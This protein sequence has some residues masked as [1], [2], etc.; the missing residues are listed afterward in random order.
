MGSIT[1]QLRIYWI[2]FFVSVIV[3]TGLSITGFHS[4]QSGGIPEN[5]IDKVNELCQWIFRLTMLFSIVLL[6]LGATIYYRTERGFILWL[7]LLI[8]VV[9]IMMT[10][11]FIEG[12]LF[13]FK[14]EHNLWEGGFSV[15]P[16]IGIFLSLFSG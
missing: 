14:K 9:F 1:N 15:S 3:L 4:L 5:V 12:Q 13:Q 8:L 10:F 7:P 11:G 16:V 6:S 2:L